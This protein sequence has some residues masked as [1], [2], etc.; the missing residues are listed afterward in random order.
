MVLAACGDA[1]TTVPAT[2]TT[3]PAAAATNTTAPAAAATDTTAP[4]AA[5][6]DTTAPAAAATNT[7]PPAAAESPTV[8]PTETTVVLGSGSAKTH[9]TMWHQYEGAYLQTIQSVLADYTA[10]HPDIAIDLLHVSDVATKAQNAVPAGVGPDM[11]A[12]VNDRIGDNALIGIIDPLDKYGVDKAYLDANF[13][14]SAATGM[15]WDNQAWAMPE[16]MEAV[17]MFYNKA[18][19]KEAD[20]PK[21]TTELLAK[22]KE[23][24]AANPGKYYAVWDLKNAYTAAPFFY[25]AGAYYVDEQGKVGVNS[26]EGVATLKWFQSLDGLLPK[27]VDYGIATTLFQEGKAPILFNGPWY[28]ADA[29]KAGVDFGLAKLPMVD[30]GTGGVAR[31]FVGVKCWMLAAKAKNAQAA[32]DLMKWYTEEAQQV[33]L[34][35]GASLVPANKAA[36]AEVQSDPVIAAFLAQAADGVP[37]PNTPYMNALWD[38]VQKAVAAAFTKPSDDAATI[39]ADAQQAA[40]S[41]VATMK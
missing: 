10:Q 17:T 31:P 1:A 8:A 40:V 16:S 39:A 41:A 28:I 3:A 25:G 38:P 9:I 6:T 37:Q 32:V 15:V 35:K 2:A 19:I 11:I 24:N 4:A 18:M 21:N 33:K 7:P 14:S 23:Y 20:L 27:E 36:S 12:W 29:R 5:A 22:A 26:P 13:V 34:S 30:F